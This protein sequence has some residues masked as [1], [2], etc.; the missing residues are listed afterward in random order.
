MN[1]ESASDKGP[2]ERIL[3]VDDDDMMLSFLSAVL[4][5]EGYAVD[6]VE[7]GAEAWEQ[8]RREMPS[9]VVC[10]YMLPGLD[11][12]AL[13]SKL[14]SHNRFRHVP[15]IMLTGNADPVQMVEN[16]EG[17]ADDYL[18]KPVTAG[19]L[20]KRVQTVLNKQTSGPSLQGNLRNLTLPDLLQLL[21][22]NRR[23]GLLQVSQGAE[24]FVFAFDEG[25]LVSVENASRTA[26]G[27]KAV[28][29]ALS[30]DDG[31]FAF[32]SHDDLPNAYQLGDECQDDLASVGFL[33]MEGLR[34]RD[35][36]PQQ[37]AAFPAPGEEWIRLSAMA[38]VS[39]LAA[40][41]TAYLTPGTEPERLAAFYRRVPP[42]GFWGE[43]A[44]ALGEDAAVVRR[45]TLLAGGGH[46]APRYDD[47]TIGGA[48]A[49]LA[50]P[51]Q[52][53]SAAD[54]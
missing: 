42:V 20:I 2:P 28:F 25:E 12:G 10:D 4:S 14:R 34:V 35:E 52:S 32:H 30:A 21:H 3:L 26:R 13:L 11:G 27:R 6:T 36:L 49:G 8:I 38:L 18:I 16:L 33:C 40:V 24:Q 48:V 19:E 37:L 46:V 54:V 31:D 39:T 43:T 53:A 44:K 9:L 51:R 1:E 7:D 5:D 17:G 50:P 47:A 41:G 29:R 22:Q 45:Q 23:S 15:F